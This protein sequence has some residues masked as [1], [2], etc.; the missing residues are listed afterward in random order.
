MLQRGV[1]KKPIRTNQ[2]RK[3]RL[4]AAGHSAETANPLAAGP[5]NT[6]S[7]A[8]QVPAERLRSSPPRRAHLPRAAPSFLPSLLPS[9]RPQLRSPAGRVPG[10]A[11]GVVGGEHHAAG[12]GPP[13]HGAGRRIPS[14]DT[15]AERGGPATARRGPA[16]CRPRSGAG[17]V[18]AALPAARRG[19]APPPGSGAA[20]SARCFS[21]GPGGTGVLR[22]AGVRAKVSLRKNKK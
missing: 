5:E 20:G 4:G 22:A 10:P 18:T 15:E 1:G 21:R 2:P 13:A 16:S 19:R 8:Q 11:A 9:C 7:P 14:G 17:P 6:A 3:N 12:A